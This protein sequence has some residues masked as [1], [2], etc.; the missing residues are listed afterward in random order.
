V[1]SCALC[2]AGVD[3]TWL[4]ERDKARKSR[5]FSQDLDQLELQLT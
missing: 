5:G 2:L 4:D 3:A 1:R